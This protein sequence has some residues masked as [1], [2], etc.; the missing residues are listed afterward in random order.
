LAIGAEYIGGQQNWRRGSTQ[1]SDDAADDTPAKPAKPAASTKVKTQVDAS[2]KKTAETVGKFAHDVETNVSKTV[3][4]VAGALKPHK[5]KT[6]TTD[7]QGDESS[8]KKSSDS[9]AG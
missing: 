2:V 6:T 1:D 8:D 5:P 4:A 7:K 9:S 3:D